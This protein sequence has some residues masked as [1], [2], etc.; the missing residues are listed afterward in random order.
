MK[1]KKRD[2]EAEKLIQQNRNA[3]DTATKVS[4]SE[5]QNEGN[6]N[7]N[8]NKSQRSCPTKRKPITAEQDKVQDEIFEK[9]GL[10][11]NVYGNSYHS[12][13]HQVQQ[14]SSSS[15]PA[16]FSP[17][18]SSSSSSGFHSSSSPEQSSSQTR[19]THPSASH[20]NNSQTP[21]RQSNNSA[22]QAPPRHLTA[23][24]FSTELL[25]SPM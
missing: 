23:H 17:G 2:K 21:T 25:T 11:E 9:I 24:S 12:P 16:R 22:M 8:S 7:N 19:G 3:V 5:L 13:P 1:Q 6:A 14:T 20:Y 10:S 15:S 18:S 4:G